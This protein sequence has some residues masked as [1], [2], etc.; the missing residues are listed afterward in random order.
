MKVNSNGGFSLGGRKARKLRRK[1]A[2]E[3]KQIGDRLLGTRR[4]EQMPLVIKGGVMKEVRKENE[5]HL[6]DSV[7]GG[8]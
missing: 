6:L 2:R 3:R 8:K 5:V 1:Y 7:K 4:S